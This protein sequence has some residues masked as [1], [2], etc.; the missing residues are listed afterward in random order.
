VSLLNSSI[1]SDLDDGEKCDEIRSPHS[2]STKWGND[3]L[4]RLVGYPKRN[5][6]SISAA[7]RGKQRLFRL[8]FL[9]EPSG[10]NHSCLLS[11]IALM[12]SPMPN[13]NVMLTKVTG[14]ILVRKR[15]HQHTSRKLHVRILP[16]A[17]TG[18]VSRVTSWLLRASRHVHIF[19][20]Q[21]W[22][23]LPLW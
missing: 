3:P 9:I 1:R 12:V 5:G 11:Y 18:V 21:A 2:V 6:S 22:P 20:I 8:E 17:S 4:S 15:H 13:K 16:T 19:W 7:C 10:G 14:Q 23:L